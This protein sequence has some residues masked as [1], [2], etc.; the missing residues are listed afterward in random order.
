MQK[1][2]IRSFPYLGILNLVRPGVNLFNR[3][4]GSYKQLIG[5]HSETSLSILSNSIEKSIYK[6]RRLKI[7]I[8]GKIDK[9]ILKKKFNIYDF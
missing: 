4:L 6:I 2:N 8:K 1:L 3:L 5:S 7:K 9:E